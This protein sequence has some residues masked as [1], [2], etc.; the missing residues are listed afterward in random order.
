MGKADAAAINLA[1]RKMA[2]DRFGETAKVR[3]DGRVIYDIGVYQ[4]KAPAESTGPWDY[5]RRLATV[6][7]ADAFRPINDGGCASAQQASQ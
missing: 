3:D 4:V 1:M 7:G 5:Y 2:V 6:S